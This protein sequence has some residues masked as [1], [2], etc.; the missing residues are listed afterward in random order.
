MLIAHIHI[1]IKCTKFSK[2]D[3]RFSPQVTVSYTGK[4]SVNTELELD[5]Y[6]E[7]MIATSYQELKAEAEEALALVEWGMLRSVQ[8]L[9]RI[10]K[11]NL[12]III[13][14]FNI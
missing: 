8:D 5:Q 10:F 13:L 1:K 11:E 9:D 3:A 6:S 14:K 12:N 4:V 2:N 7:E